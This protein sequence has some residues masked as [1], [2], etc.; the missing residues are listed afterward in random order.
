MLPAWPSVTHPH[1]RPKLPLR[2]GLSTTALVVRDQPEVGTLSG[3]DKSGIPIRP[4]T[5]RHS[6]PP[7]SLTR[8]STGPPSRAA[9]H[10]PVGTVGLTTFRTS[11]IPEGVRSRLSAGGATSA[12]GEPLA[13]IPGHLPFWSK[14]V[15]P[16]GLFPMTTARRRSTSVDH[17]FQPWLPTALR[18]A[19][20]V[21]PRDLTAGPEDRGFVV[22][23]ASHPGVTTDA[24]SGRV[25]VA[26]HRIV[27]DKCLHDFVSHNVCWTKPPLGWH[28]RSCK[29]DCFQDG[30]GGLGDAPR[31]R[32]LRRS[33]R[34]P[35]AMWRSLWWPFSPTVVV[36][37][38]QIQSR[39]QAGRPGAVPEVRAVSLR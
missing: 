9:F 21:S 2:L 5:G 12:K 35:R 15:S 27:R 8:S 17:T 29:G 14:P 36:S 3:R 4:I 26:E 22:P 33:W 31:R 18:L 32:A 16:F 20:A 30:P 24:R 7:A 25:P 23:E 37:C 13:P 6:L 28:T 19:V 38:R 10:I 1:H 39:A 34:R 11:T